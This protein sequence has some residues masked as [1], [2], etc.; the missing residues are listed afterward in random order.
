MGGR[1]RG[2]VEHEAVVEAVDPGG[3][4][5]LTLRIEPAVNVHGV[6]KFR[7][8]PD[9]LLDIHTTAGPDLVSYDERGHPLCHG[10]VGSI[11][12]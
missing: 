5:L 9:A 3:T 12:C 11:G 1:N 10:A 7:R 6:D 2:S 8:F 4:G